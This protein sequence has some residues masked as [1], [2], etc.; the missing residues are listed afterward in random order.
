MILLGKEERN[1]QPPPKCSKEKSAILCV[2]L[3][4]G[5]IQTEKVLFELARWNKRAAQ[6][7]SNGTLDLMHEV[8]NTSLSA[9][10]SNSLSN[11]ISVYSDTA[12]DGMMKMAD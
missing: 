6:R 8:Q 1:K 5:L 10:L 12:A 4:Q 2:P 9:V 11:A 7:R 3:R